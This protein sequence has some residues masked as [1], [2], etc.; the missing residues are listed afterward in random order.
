MNDNDFRYY[1]Y[2]I[3][4]GCIFFSFICALVSLLFVRN[5]LSFIAGIVIGTITLSVNLLLLELVVAVMSGRNRITTGIV[6]QVV[7]F[8]IFGITAFAAYK[9]STLAVIG[10]AV[11]VLGLPI[12]SSI[13]F[14]RKEG[15]DGKL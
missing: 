8:M 2:R 13:I 10:Y 7:R 15:A 14:L 12:S 9:I 6:I 11:S 5:D 4:A 3:I 1:K